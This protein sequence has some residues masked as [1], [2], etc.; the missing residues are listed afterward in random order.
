[1]HFRRYFLILFFINLFSIPV[2]SKS[3]NIGI[4]NDAYD[5]LML[6]AAEY[7]KK[8]AQIINYDISYIHLPA[9]RS[10]MLA[11]NGILDGEF[12]RHRLIEALNP[13]LVRVDVPL[14]QFDYYIWV[15]EGQE[16][17]RDVQA[18]KQM[19]PVG[20]R[21]VIFFDTLVYPLSDVSHAEVNTMPQ[22]LQI[23]N[24]RRADYTVHNHMVMHRYAQLSG[25]HIK[26][27]LDEPLFSMPFYLY[28]HESKRDLIPSLEQAMSVQK[29][30]P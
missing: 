27:C 13:S 2:H 8:A 21:G 1:M 4:R 19:K 18:L 23:L 29:T 14:G 26:R 17:V 7:V 16:C 5:P 10:L 25:I 24:R 30:Q 11:A 3:L 6:K 20:V 28:L 12:Y 22:V 15:L 9:K